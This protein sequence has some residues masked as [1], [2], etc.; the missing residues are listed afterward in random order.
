MYDEPF[1]LQKV[2]L[3]SSVSIVYVLT[4]LFGWY[5]LHPV[6]YPADIRP[7]SLTRSAQKPLPAAAP[8]KA[9]ISGKPVRIV[10][11]DSGI[12]LPVDEGYYNSAERSWTLSG[13]HAHFAMVSSPANDAGGDTFIY[14]HNNN[15]VFGP[16]RH[17]APEPGATALLYTDNGHVFSYSFQSSVS[18]NPDDTLILDYKG[19]P[20]LTIQTCTGS[21]DEWRTFF[22][23]KFEKVVQ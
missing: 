21:V 4:L 5:V 23:F 18:L 9:V 14:G 13:Y 1:G 20:I 19:P 22:K 16:L 10:I 8:A 6:T 2:R 7:V 15:Y 17:A 12:D 3:A 11:P